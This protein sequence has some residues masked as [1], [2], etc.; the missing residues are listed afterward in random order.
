MYWAGGCPARVSRKRMLYPGE[1]RFMVPPKPPINWRQVAEDVTGA[2]IIFALLG[3]LVFI[4][5]LGL[6]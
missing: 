4:L 3:F 5:A 1:K 6:G 2:V